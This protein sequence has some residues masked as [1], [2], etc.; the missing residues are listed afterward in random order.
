MSVCYARIVRVSLMFLRF[1][2]QIWASFEVWIV[3]KVRNGIDCAYG[4]CESD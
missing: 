4:T 3:V 2:G 1:V